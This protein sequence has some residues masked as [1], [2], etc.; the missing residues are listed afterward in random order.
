MAALMDAL[1]HY[2]INIERIFVGKSARIWQCCFWSNYVKHPSISNWIEPGK[3][4]LLD[5]RQRGPGI[6]VGTGPGVFS[7]RPCANVIKPGTVRT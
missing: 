4:N 7:Q 3:S 2:S 5:P 1:P 6:N